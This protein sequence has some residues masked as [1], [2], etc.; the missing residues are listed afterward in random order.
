MLTKPDLTQAR[1]QALKYAHYIGLHVA[2]CVYTQSKYGPKSFKVAKM[3]LG[4]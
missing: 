4:V 3:T 2:V 1:E